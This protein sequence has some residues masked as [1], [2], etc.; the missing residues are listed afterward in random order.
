MLAR[1]L[2]LKGKY[3]EA[4]AE[5]TAILPEIR[6]L[7]EAPALYLRALH[8]LG[9]VKEAIEFGERYLAE[10]PGDADVLAMLSTLYVDDGDMQKAEA[11]AQR[12]VA[13]RDIPKR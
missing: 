9:E 11:V 5:L 1:V 10:S 7:P 3:A 8:Y 2:L 12:A 13:A 4:K 6:R